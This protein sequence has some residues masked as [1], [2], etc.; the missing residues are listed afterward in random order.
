MQSFRVHRLRLGRPR[1][2]SSAE[3]AAIKARPWPRLP[4]WLWLAALATTVTMV[5]VAAALLRAAPPAQPVGAR[6]SPPA[7]GLTH[8]VGAYRVPAL[9]AAEAG[10]VVRL[11]PDCARLADV[12]VIG[13]S[14]EAALLRAAVERLCAFRS[15][16]PIQRA[17]QALERTRAEVAFAEFQLSGNESTTRLGPGRPLVLVNGK[18][19]T[20]SLPDRISVELVHE[21]T[22]LAAGR[23][24]TA[25][26]ELAA[27]K[28]ELEAC[29]LLPADASPNRGCAD[30]AGLLSG[31]DAS[32]LAALRQGGYR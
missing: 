10:R 32:A 19:S 6:R 22:L 4:W 27:V 28:A 15:T 26:D 7:A 13:A 5:V 21:G 8:G 1:R 2:L 11:R 9:S 20:T 29:R 30:A 25:A 12:T 14:G 23:A 3:A 24:P 18:F 17:R 31:D 16:P